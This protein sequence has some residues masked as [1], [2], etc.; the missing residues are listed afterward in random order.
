MSKPSIAMCCNAYQDVTALRGLL[1]T[2]APFFDNLF[3]VHSGPGGVHST[4]GTIE[5]CE[6]MGATIVFDDIQRGFGAIRT[7]LIH[8]CGCTWAFILDADERF[9]PRI[10]VMHCEGEE[11]FPEQQEPNLST[12]KREEIQDQ[13][14]ILRGLMEMPRLKAIRTSR[15]HWIDFTLNKPAQNWLR[16]PDWQLR[17]VKNLPEVA[18]Q[19]DRV[20]HERLLDAN[21]GEDPAYGD[22]GLFHD[23]Y[24]CYFRRT[25]PGKKEANEQNYSR[26]ER[27]E[28]MIA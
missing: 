25:Q 23:H 10:P 4:D 26:L 3:V 13:G 18:Y 22:S 9:H 15:R 7:R 28:A 27:G 2:S 11:K 20:M 16:I 17:I 19:K 14:A 5:L 12:F 24:H 6:Q 8:D 1:E 21:T